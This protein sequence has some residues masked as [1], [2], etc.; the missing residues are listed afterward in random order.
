MLKRFEIRPRSI[1]L[2]DGTTPK[3]YH[4][5]QFEDAWNRHLTP[6]PPKLAATAP[7]PA[8]LS[9]KQPIPIRHTKPLVADSKVAANQHEQSDVAAV[10]DSNGGMDEETAQIEDWF[11][12]DLVQAELDYFREQAKKPPV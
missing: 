11:G 2:D 4:R 9:G 3:G 8:S 6:D 1:R 12:P 10:A 7:Q 5:E